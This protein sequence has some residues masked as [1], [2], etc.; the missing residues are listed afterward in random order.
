MILAKEINHKNLTKIFEPNNFDWRNHPKYLTKIFEPTDTTTCAKEHGKKDE[1]S[2]GKEVEEKEEGR[3][4]EGA[5]EGRREE[6]SDE[7]FA[8]ISEEEIR[9]SRKLSSSPGSSSSSEASP[10]YKSEPICTSSALLSLESLREKPLVDSQVRLRDLL[11]G[12]ITW[13]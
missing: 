10:K 8:F 7:D 9:N 6:E 1:K 13:V 4:K 12:W 3:S 5:G 2:K 11:R